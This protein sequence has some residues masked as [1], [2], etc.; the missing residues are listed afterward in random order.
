LVRDHLRDREEGQ[1]QRSGS[2]RD[3]RL[4]GRFV[5]SASETIKKPVPNTATYASKVRVVAPSDLQDAIARKNIAYHWAG[6]QTDALTTHRPSRTAD[7]ARMNNLG[8]APVGE[9]SVSGAFELLPSSSSSEHR[10]THETQP[11]P[12]VRRPIKTTITMN[13]IASPMRESASPIAV[14]VTGSPARQEHRPS[15]AVSE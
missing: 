15:V 9:A 4:G 11:D 13:W 1:R 2:L 10:R 14:R 8:I 5:R 3:D 12:D 7:H 6:Y